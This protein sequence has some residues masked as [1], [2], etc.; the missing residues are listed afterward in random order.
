M[1]WDYHSIQLGAQQGWQCPICGRV[2]APW[3]AQC[4]CDGKVPSH[5]TTAGTGT[6]VKIDYARPPY[7]I[8]STGTPLQQQTWTSSSTSQD[9]EECMG[10][11]DLCYYCK[12][13]DHFTYK[14]WTT[15][16]K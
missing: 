1:D 9:C 15:E 14:G 7:T 11:C 6:T 5:T 2:N 16:R 13:G 12:N 10:G 3:M 8:G 4:T